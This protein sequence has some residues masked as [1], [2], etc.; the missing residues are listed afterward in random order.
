MP[1][2]TTKK[3]SNESDG[4]EFFAAIRQIEAIRALEQAGALSAL[5]ETL[6]E[7]VRLRKEFPSEG[8]EELAARAGISKSGMNHRMRKLSELA[9]RLPGRGES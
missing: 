5:P 6:Q 9:A 8:L 7:A 1:R 3:P 2:K 4:K